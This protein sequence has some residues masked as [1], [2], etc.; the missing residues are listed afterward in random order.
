MK[1][2][3]LLV[4]LLVLAIAISGCIQIPPVD[5]G[6]DV[7]C[8]NEHF[9][10]CSP[11]TVT[12][13]K[14]TRIT[15]YVAGTDNSWYIVTEGVTAKIKGFNG[16]FGPLCEIEFTELW[17]SGKCSACGYKYEKANCFFYVKEKLAKQCYKIE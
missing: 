5:C 8:F 7:D 13:P 12:F 4:A 9:D 3:I 2:K 14:D 17:S 16:L 1:E 6:T 10:Q 11:A 15:Y